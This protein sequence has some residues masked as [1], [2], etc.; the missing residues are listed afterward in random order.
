MQDSKGNLFDLVKDI[1]GKFDGKSNKELLLAI[2]KE[3]KKS[4]ENGT[5]TNQEIDNFALILSPFLDEKQ[6][7]LLSKLILE[8]KKI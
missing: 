5:L 4:K 2:Y 8:L 6:N 1:A 3:A 7:K